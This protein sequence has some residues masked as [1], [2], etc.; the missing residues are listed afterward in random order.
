MTTADDGATYRSRPHEEEEE[1]VIN[2]TAWQLPPDGDVSCNVTATPETSREE[3]QSG[4][5]ECHF[6]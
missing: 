5:D 1:L 3:T 4:T 6:F 2:A